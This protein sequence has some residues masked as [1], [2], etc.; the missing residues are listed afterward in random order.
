MLPNGLKRFIQRCENP[1][2]ET[3]SGQ[4]STTQNVGTDAEISLLVAKDHQMALK[5]TENQLNINQ[6]FHEDLGNKKAC[7]KFVPYS[8]SHKQQK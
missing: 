4:P 5:L 7:A 8:F 2:D 6:I 1:E 3:R